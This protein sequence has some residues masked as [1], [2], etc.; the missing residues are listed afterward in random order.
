MP[1][2]IPDTSTADHGGFA[3]FYEQHYVEAVRLAG[4]LSSDRTTAEDLAQEAF[5]RLQP[6]FDR[7]R[8][9]GGYLRTTLVNLCRNIHRSQ[10]RETKRHTRHGPTPSTMLDRSS[11]LDA[12][13]RRLP[14]VE[15]AVDAGGEWFRTTP[16]SVRDAIETVK[17]DR[18]HGQSPGARPRPD[19][20]PGWSSSS[21]RTAA[22]SNRGSA[23][24]TVPGLLALPARALKVRPWWLGL[25]LAM[26]AV[27]ALVMVSPIIVLVI[28]YT[29]A[30]RFHDDGRTW[31]AIGVAVAAVVVAVLLGIWAVRIIADDR[32]SDDPASA[33]RND[34]LVTLR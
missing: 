7:V 31:H 34:A 17:R 3:L 15:R 10:R 24:L 4:F 32:R 28:G 30:K 20:A 27:G 2:H 12:S 19:G 9:P 14:Y 26:L 16:Q 5:L 21:T 8:N 33:E 23:P 13:L 6:E 29:H 11:E 22:R 25:T 18:N 1:S